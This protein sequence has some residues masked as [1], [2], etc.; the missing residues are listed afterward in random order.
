VNVTLTENLDLVADIGGTN[1]RFALASRAGAL[2]S[3]KV[4]KCDDFEG[5]VEAVRTHLAERDPATHAS[6]SIAAA[7]DGDQVHMTNSNNIESVARILGHVTSTC[8]AIL[9][10]VVTGLD[11]VISGKGA[12]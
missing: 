6:F 10:F 3:I 9:F 8:P 7:L 1:A 4:L 11:P 5:P 2:S 12:G